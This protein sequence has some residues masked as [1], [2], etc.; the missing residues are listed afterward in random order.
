MSDEQTITL[1]DGRAVLLR[2]SCRGDAEGVHA[3]ICALGC[4]T[5]MILTC[6]EDLPPIERIQS[7]IEMI[8][9]GRF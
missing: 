2:H 3:H 5:E 1:R 6:A 4:S 9:K 8:E 7:H